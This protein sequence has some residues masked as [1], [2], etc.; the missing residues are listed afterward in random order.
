MSNR[1]FR[2]GSL[3]K[4]Q[5]HLRF[6]APLSFDHYDIERRE[7]VFVPRRL[8]NPRAWWSAVKNAVRFPRINNSFSI[9]RITECTHRCYCPTG[10]SIDGRIWLMGFGVNIW[11]SH[12]RGEVPCPCDIALAELDA[13]MEAETKGTA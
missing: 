10:S 11:Y 12:F 7:C 6:F 4:R 1:D 8:L 3:E 13:E 9:R 5:L 2:F